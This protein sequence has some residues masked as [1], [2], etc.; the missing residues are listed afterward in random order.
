MA[1]K[2]WSNAVLR[3]LI[4]AVLFFLLAIA[5]GVLGY[6]AWYAIGAFLGACIRGA[7]WLGCKY[8]N[9]LEAGGPWLMLPVGIAFSFGLAAVLEHLGHE[10]AGPLTVVGSMVCGGIVWLVLTRL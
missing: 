6:G 7:A 1:R 3:E 4:N 5:G 10:E 9:R 8:T 2:Q